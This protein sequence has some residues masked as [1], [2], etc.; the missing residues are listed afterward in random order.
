LPP[1]SG[2]ISSGT[3]ASVSGARGFRSTRTASVG[4][5]IAVGTHR[6]W[7]LLDFLILEATE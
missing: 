1:K 7:T 4:D 6:S 5:G 3:G 2:V